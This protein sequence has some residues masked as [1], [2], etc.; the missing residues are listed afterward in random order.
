MTDSIVIAG[1]GHAAG[2]AAVSLRQGGFTGRIVMIGEEPYLPY[3]RP[4]LSK[5]FLSGELELDRMYVRHQKFY[6]EHNIDVRLSTRVETINRDDQTVTLSDGSTESYNRLIIATGSEVRRLNIPGHDLAG[7]NYLRSVADVEAIQENFKPGANLVII[8]AGYIGMEVAAIGISMGLD[9]TVVES[10][11]RIMARALAPEVSVFF[12][13]VHRE[14]GVKILCDRDPN[15]ELLGK[16]GKVYAL[17]AADGM[18]IPA[19]LVI[20]GIG[21]LPTATLAEAAGLECDNGIVVDEYCHTS[22]PH[23]FAIGDCTN[24][25]NSLLGKRLRLESVHNAQEQA[26]TAAAALCGELKPYNQI[27]WFWSDQYDLKLQIVGLSGDHD[28]VVIRGSFEDRSF[29]AFYM[30]GDLL[31]AVDAVNSAR[32]F[33]LSKKLIA[34]G[35]R[36]DP[37]ILADTSIEFKALATAALN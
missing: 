37:E 25:P 11:P 33:M 13:Q 29:A 26:K 30:K 9:V 35:A 22:D 27:P 31:I 1:A 32:E 14:A 10:A 7:V 8:G 23:I 28:Q 3:Q 2:Q 6:D 34:Q 24:H 5:K 19:D 20:V 18:E 16:D 17:K 4:P 36:I 12:D 15:S 21:I